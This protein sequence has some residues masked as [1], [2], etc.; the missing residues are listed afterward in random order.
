M[1]FQKGSLKYIGLET[2]LETERGRADQLYQSGVVNA[3]I[4]YE[5]GRRVG[6]ELYVISVGQ[7]MYV[8]SRG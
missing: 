1:V 2:F 5:L 4:I 7:N 8:L 6:Q 3:H